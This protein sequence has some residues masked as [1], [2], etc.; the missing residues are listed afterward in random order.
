MS[1]DVAILN[2]AVQRH[3]LSYPSYLFGHN[4]YL[5]YFTLIISYE[6]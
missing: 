5:M 1:Y 6:S 2:T 4:S 3:I